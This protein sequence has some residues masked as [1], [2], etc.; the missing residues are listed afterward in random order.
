MQTVKCV[1]IIIA[2]TIKGENLWYK[3][4]KRES[5]EIFQMQFAM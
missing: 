1:K 5:T 3:L 2:R 4:Q